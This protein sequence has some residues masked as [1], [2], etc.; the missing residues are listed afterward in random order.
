MKPIV[1]LFA[2]AGLAA[3]IFSQSAPAPPEPLLHIRTSFDLLVHASYAVTAPLFGP[4]GERAYAGKHWD[5]AFIYP[6]PASDV[7]GAVFTVRHGPY[8][9]VWVTSLADIEGRHFQYVYFLQDLMVT[10][11]DVHF[12]PIGADSTSVNV[13]YTRTA[14][15]AKGNEHV[16]TMSDDDKTAGKGWQQAIDE[17]LG[18]N[19]SASTP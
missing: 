3:P 13:V 19:K 18:R 4:Q 6:Q 10:V 1:A 16:K 11:V 7:E 9:A 12:K 2:A 14:L 15:T 5:P 8:N 17:Y